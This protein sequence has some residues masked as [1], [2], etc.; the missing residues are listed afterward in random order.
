MKFTMNTVKLQDM[1]AKAMKGASN[2]KLIPLTN[3]MAIQ[4]KDHKLTLITTDATNF[5]YI[6]EDKVA[7]DCTINL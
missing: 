4:L 1:V 7:G 2:N 5:L 3:L 6:M